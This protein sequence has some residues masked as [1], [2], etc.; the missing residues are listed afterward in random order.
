MI[1]ELFKN[2]EQVVN[3]LLNNYNVRRLN[4]YISLYVQNNSLGYNHT[5]T[6]I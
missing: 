1:L 6:S 3:S 2:F 4:V 5:L